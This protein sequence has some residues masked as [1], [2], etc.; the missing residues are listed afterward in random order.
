MP[1]TSA[2]LVTRL[3]EVTGAETNGDLVYK[4]RLHH[5]FKTDEKQISRWS[6]P[7][8]SGPQWAS[9]TVLLEIAG[10]L[11][12]AALGVK[13]RAEAAVAKD[14]SLALTPKE[15]LRQSEETG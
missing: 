5:N 12:P 10:W 6:K 8:P 9:A 3:K 14:A 7:G 4:L 11:S 1:L 15:P 13:A 2:Q